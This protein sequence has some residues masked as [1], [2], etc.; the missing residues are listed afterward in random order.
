MSIPAS[1]DFALI[2]VQATAGPPATWTKLCG[3]ENVNINR[4][5]Q[6]SESYRRD[7]DKPN[8]PGQRKLRVTGSSWTVTGSGADN[9]DL[10]EDYEDG[11]GVR[12]I[13][14][15]ELYEDDGTDLGALMGHFIGTALNT[16]WNQS[17]S[18]DASGTVETTLEGEGLLTWTPVT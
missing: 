11:F 2:Y 5:A 8:R 17:Y 3:L 18:A 14:K 6:T 9:I 10:Y 4:A 15:I 13:Y 16:A 1:A 12:K 7:C